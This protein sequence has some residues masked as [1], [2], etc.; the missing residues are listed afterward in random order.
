MTEPVSDIRY[1]ERNEID[2][3]KWDQCILSAPNG[4][5]YARSFYLDAMSENWSGL[6]AGD[7]QYVM[8]LTWN[9]KAG[10]KYLYQPYF[11]K[12]L[13][14]FGNSSQSFEISSFLHAIPDIYRYWDIDLNENNFVSTDIRKLKQRARRN[15]LLS[16]AKDYKQISQQYKRLANRMTKKA[17]EGKVQIVRGESPELIIQLYRR[18]YANRHKSISGPVYERLK[19]CSLN[20]FKNNL[21]ETYLAKSPDG[22]T[23][24]YYMI[25]KDEHYIYS[26]LGGSTGEGKRQGAF[27]LLTD[28]I[29]RDHAGT[30]KIFRFE[31]SD[32]PGI[33]FF[34]NLFGP[35]RISYQH[36]VMNKLPFL[37]RFLK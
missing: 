13:G 31:G 14:V 1:L 2:T 25:L 35:E 3:V 20:A 16:L 37:I 27:Y 34:D 8:P 19:G 26:L 6:V 32:I 12:S 21:A 15:Y 17:I 28:A 22:E 24:A 10:I 9:R 11:T 23:L 5:I 30:D 33:S 4:L 7:Y 18:D 36:L 29:I